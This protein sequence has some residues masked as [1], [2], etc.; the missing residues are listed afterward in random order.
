MIADYF[1]SYSPSTK[2][3]IGR[4]RHT[5]R[6][7]RSCLLNVLF[8]NPPHVHVPS[9]ARDFIFCPAMARVLLYAVPLV[10][11]YAR[12][13]P[14][15]LMV[16]LDTVLD[17]RTAAGVLALSTVVSALVSTLTSLSP[18]CPPDPRLTHVAPPVSRRRHLPWVGVF[19]AKLKLPPTPTEGNPFL[20]SLE[21]Q[22]LFSGAYNQGQQGKCQAQNL[23]AYIV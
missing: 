22:R 2:H 11:D 3:D 17:G 6:H 9:S 20:P 8:D 23:R 12:L 10:L 5:E 19:T 15:L 7:P 18:L 16:D 1:L 14:L 21:T 13:S 4:P